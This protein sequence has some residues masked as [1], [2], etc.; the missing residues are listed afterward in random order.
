MRASLLWPTDLSPPSKEPSGI[1]IESIGQIGTDRLDYMFL[2]VAT[3]FNGA[4]FIA[5]EMAYKEECPCHGA[6]VL[7]TGQQEHLPQPT[8]STRYT[9][10]AG[11]MARHWG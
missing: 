9:R 1:Y 8:L 11:M 4:L 7:K 10:G 6:T 3:Q 2:S 5:I